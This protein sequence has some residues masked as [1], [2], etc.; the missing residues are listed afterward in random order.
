MGH[1]I[2]LIR[3]KISGLKA[4]YVG[5]SGSNVAFSAV[6]NR[7]SSSPGLPT[8]NPTTSFWF[9]NPPFPELVD[10]K[11]EKVPGTGYGD[12]LDVAI[13]GSG[14]TGAAV[15]WGLLQGDETDGKP[16]DGMLRAGEMQKNDMRVLMLEARSICSGATGRNGG[17]VKVRAYEEFSRLKT[18]FGIER[19]KEIVRFQRRHLEILT[20]LVEAEGLEM[21]ELREME[22]VDF[23]TEEEVWEDAKWMVKMLW[24]TEEMKN[25]SEEMM[26]WEGEEAREAGHSSEFV[27][28]TIL[29][30][31]AE[32]SYEQSHSRSD[33][34]PRRSTMALPTRDIHSLISAFQIWSQILNRDEHASREYHH[35]QRS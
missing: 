33:F 20:H 22:T 35:R 9:R 10:R 26:V 12:V 17:H 13:I 31:S 32:I 14:I 29:M 30:K 8:S 24:G 28:N 25:V 21:A 23:F 11:S 2:S 16:V 6:L 18:R 4:L 3:E 15:A 27:G 19:A 34:V 5:I 1:T 7:I